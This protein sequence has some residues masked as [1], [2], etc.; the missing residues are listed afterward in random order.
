MAALAVSLSAGPRATAGTVLPGDPG[1]GDVAFTIDASASARPISPYIYGVNGELRP[2]GLGSY[3]LGGN[4]W[5]GYNWETNSSNAGSDFF[6][7]SDALLV[8]FVNNTPAGEALRPALNEGASLGMAV[9]VTVPIAGYVAAD[10][11]QEVFPHQAAPSSRWKELRPRKSSVYPGAALS[12]TPNRNDNYV[13]TD[14]LINWVESRRVGGQKV[15]YSLDNEPGLWDLTHPRLWGTTTASFAQVADLSIAHASTIKDI[16]PAAEVMGGVLYGWGAFKDLDG[17]PDFNAQ[18]PQPRDPLGLHFNRWFL[19]RMAQEEAAQGRVLMDMLDLHWYSEATGGGTRVTFG[20]AVSNSPEVVA[21]R[22]QAPRSLWDP[23]YV[24]TSW[25]TQFSTGGQ[26]IRLL[27]RVQ[28]DIDELKPGTRISLSEY[29]HGGGNHI[30][31]GIAQADTLGILGREGVYNASWFPIEPTGQQQ[32]IRGAFEMFTDFDGQGRRFGDL[33][34]TATTD[35]VADSS[36]YAS[37]STGDPNELIL[38]AINKTATPQDAA[39]RVTADRR[40]T[41]AE[42]FTLTSASSTPT[43][44][45]VFPIDAVNA[46][47]Y[48]MPAYSVSTIRLSVPSLVGDFNSDGAVDVADYTVWRDT[49][50]S[51]TDLRADANGNGFIDGGDINFWRANYGATLSGTAIAAPEPAGALLAAGLVAAAL[52][53]RRGIVA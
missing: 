44:A 51:T 48:E 8:G 12:L 41:R 27:D 32:F 42:V 24:E 10:N 1:P 31:G 14:E 33:S 30:S 18:V 6:H 28:A 25:I 37:L 49:R 9:N 11:N 16:A 23:T 13:F 22:L 35:D 2:S 38:V 53:R 15:M 36:V 7:Y 34:V 50:F 43:S 17:A 4:R 5:T 45:G 19:D 29:S 46:F 20:G 39:V 52:V 40:F 3:R 26:P 47:L 21:A